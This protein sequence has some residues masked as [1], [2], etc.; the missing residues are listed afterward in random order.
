MTAR[1]SCLAML[2][3]PDNTTV[4]SIII[5]PGIL[6]YLALLLSHS[7]APSLS[8][9]R[10]WSLEHNLELVPHT[11]CSGPVKRS[12]AV[13]YELGQLTQLR[14]SIRRD[15]VEVDVV[16]PLQ[17]LLVLSLVSLANVRGGCRAVSSSILLGPVAV[18]AGP[19]S[20][21]CIF[22]SINCYFR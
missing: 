18:S 21:G 22:P 11:L 13:R 7:R 2:I 12:R 14:G 16:I 17:A 8:E 4:R 19:K 9:S 15:A 1:Q 10:N 6:S 20:T 5:P 3:A